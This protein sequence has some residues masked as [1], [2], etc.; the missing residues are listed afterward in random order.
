MDGE[1][2]A[3][4]LRDEV[5]DE[6]AALR[7][8]GFATVLADDDEASH[9]YVDRKHEAAREAGIESFDHRL[10]A[11][12]SEDD[13]LAI[14]AE[15][16][17]DD[18]VDGIFVQLPL[19]EHVDEARVVAALDPRKDLDGL[20]PLN[21]GRLLLGEL[22]S[23][24]ATPQAVLAL[25]R[26]YGVELEG[27]RAT[28]VGPGPLLGTPTALLLLGANATVTV[29][30]P[31]A[32]LGLHTRGADVVVAT[33]NVPGIVGADLLDAVGGGR[34][35]RSRGRRRPCR[36]GTRRPPLAGS[37]WRGTGHDRD[38]AASRRACLA[39]APRPDQLTK[40]HRGDQHT[41]VSR[42]RPGRDPAAD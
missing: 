4:R 25:L 24:P 40:G 21:R 20:H 12:A 30:D 28:V 11:A 5:A 16:N 2:L 9:R 3:R 18:A 23:A 29:C 34:G 32:E 33:A 7:P 22:E 31:D 14:L 8:V 15:L 19:P 10:P 17:A 27:A 1:A 36:S 42:D 39:S 37:G 26:E 38:A 41:D 6:V 13:L 35:R